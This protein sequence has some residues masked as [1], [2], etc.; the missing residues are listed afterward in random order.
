MASAML[1]RGG[2][3]STSYRV[4]RSNG[5]SRSARPMVAARAAPAA[6][7]YETVAD[8]MTKGQQV[9]T[10]RPDDS[11]DK[12]LEL[13]VAHKITGLP[14][15]DVN[16]VVVGVVS[17]F[18]L[19]ALDTVGKTNDGPLFPPASETWQAFKAV[20]S[21]LAKG[22][23]KCVR[24]VMTRNAMS[25]TPDTNINEATSLLLKKRIRRLPVVD[26]NGRLVGLISR[27][28]IIKVALELRKSGGGGG[29]SP[30]PS[31]K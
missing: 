14:V 6:K 31:T 11:V 4:A 20:R 17:D 5:L 8:I 10:C 15:V 16:N 9:F 27:S 23:G 22:T 30:T 3:A 1:A 26:G 29:P 2:A 21:A 7:S 13:L 12:A 19:L 28:N 18:D 24:D 25:V